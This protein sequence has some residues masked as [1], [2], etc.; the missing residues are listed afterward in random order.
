MNEE[1]L[2]LLYRSFDSNLS[3][4]DQALLSA[5]LSRDPELREE[6]KRVE[7]MRSMVS[8]NAERSFKPF[9]SARVMRK[10]KDKAPQS[11][12]FESLV[13]IFRRVAVVGGMALIL[14]LATNLLVGR[15]FSV[16]SL[17]GIPQISLEDSYELED[18]FYGEML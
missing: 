12:F 10:I 9:F 13:W 15:D 11:D 4:E 1:L 5:G 8:E 6:K 14:L 7:Q 3:K 2:E 16:D 18:L 17:L